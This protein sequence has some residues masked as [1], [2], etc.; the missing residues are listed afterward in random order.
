MR[1]SPH[2]S[3]V[4]KIESLLKVD[5]EKNSLLSDQ[6]EKQQWCQMNRNHWTT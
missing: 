6:G 1:I 5:K 4:V 3:H 2:K